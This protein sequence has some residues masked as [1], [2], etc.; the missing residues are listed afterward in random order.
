[1]KKNNTYLEAQYMFQ[2]RKLA[3]KIIHSST[4]VLPAWRQILADL[5]KSATLMPRDVAT[6]WNSTYDMLDYAI[7]HRKA[8]DTVTQ[9]RD[10][11]LRKFELADHEWEIVKQLRDVLKV[12]HV[13]PDLSLYTLTARF[14]S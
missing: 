4:I 1:M 2:L 13:P 8:V 12:C 6:R 3:Y 10:L 9:R 11:G 5:R 14:I 7:E